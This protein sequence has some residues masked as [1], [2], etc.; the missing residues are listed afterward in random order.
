MKRKTIK[1]LI[2]VI[3]LI[4]INLMNWTMLSYG[5][6]NPDTYKALPQ[7]SSLT[8]T[9]N[10]TQ[11]IGPMKSTG[12]QVVMLISTILILAIIYFIPTAISIIKKHTYKSYIICIN[13]LLGWTLIGWLACLI[14][15]LI[16]NKK[17]L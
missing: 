7:S 15:S 4:T 3:F 14:W 12:K 2:L 8:N 16:D 9:E 11:T 1:I 13:I 17:K 6:I 5:Y 10:E